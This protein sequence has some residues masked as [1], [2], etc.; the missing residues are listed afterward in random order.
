M[1]LG[2]MAGLI[3]L[4]VVAFWTGHRDKGFMIVTG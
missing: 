3:A 1:I 4:A 2:L